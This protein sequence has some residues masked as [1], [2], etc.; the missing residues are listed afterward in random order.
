MDA[1]IKGMKEITG[2]VV[3][4]TLTLAAVL[5][6]LGFTGGLTGALF[7]EFAF[8]LAGAV[9]IS[10]I[11]ALTI[12]PAM[13]ARILKH[14]MTSRFQRFVDGSFDRVANWYERRVSSSLDYRPVTIL[15]VLAL[16]GATVFM[17][18]NTTSE[19]APEEDEGAL[20]S[21]MNGPRYATLDYMKLYTDRTSELTRGI[22]EVSTEFSITGIG[23]ATNMAFYIWVLKDWAE[24]ERSQKEIQEDI[25]GR[26]GNQTGV[27][28]FVFAPPSLPGSGG[29]LPITVVIQSIHDAERVYE[30]AEDGEEQGH[31]HRPLHRRAELARLRRAAGQRD[32][33]PRPRR[34]AQRPDQRGRE[35]PRPPRRRRLDRRVRP[36]LRTATTSSPRCRASFRENPEQLGEFFVR[37]ADGAMIPLSSVVT[38]ATDANTNSIE[39]FNQLNSAT[40]SALPLP[41]VTTGDGLAAI[42]EHH[43]RGAPRGLLHRLLGPVAPRGDQGN[44]IADRLR[45]RAPRHLPRARGAVRELPRP[46]HHPDVGAALDLRRPPAPQP[47]PRHPQH[48]HPGRAHHPD[49]AHHQAR[50]PASSSSPTSSANSTRR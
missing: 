50:H 1:A 32:D 13:A 39:Q 16:V 31:G 17:F 37:S 49:R 5:A 43:A 47:R 2:P 34:R 23:G 3:A 27:E 8:T 38:I 40:I 6:P 10:G 26:L 30:V 35:H 18:L 46:V 44:T 42:Q 12:T 20:F 7:R 11:V 36:R 25:Q 28:A 19:L 29:G 22:E 41:G 45:R 4:M 21:I 9:I 14:D 24:R 33:R 48:L 15:M